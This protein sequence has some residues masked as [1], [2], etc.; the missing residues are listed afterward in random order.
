MTL[1][2]RRSYVGAAVQCTLTS[3]ITGASS[4]ISLTGDTTAWND[5]ANGPF[6]I[7]VDPGL[8]SEEKILVGSRSTSTLSSLTRGVDGTSAQSHAAGA[9]VYP[10]FTAVDADEANKLA[11]TMT[12]KGDLL[13]TDGSTPN[14]LAVGSNNQFLV[15]DSAATNGV[16]WTGT[17]SGATVA[18]GSNT[19]SGT[20]AEFDTAV[21]DDNFAYVGTANTFTTNQVISASSSSDLLRITQTG[22]GNAILVE[23]STNP[24]STPFVVDASGYVG[25][26]TSTPYAPATYGALTVDGTTGSIYSGR[27]NGTEHFRIQ[28]TATSTTLNGIA[29]V[30]V[31]FNT[32]NTERMRIDSAGQVGIGAAAVAGRTLAVAKPLTGATTAVGVNSNGTI[33]SDVTAEANGF[34]SVINTAAASFT[35]TNLLHFYA[36]PSATPGA[37]STITT[38]IGFAV[39]NTMTGASSNNYAFY[40]DLASGT[41]RYNLMMNG[42][43]ANYLAGRLG[44]GAT[45]TSGAMAQVTNTTAADK[46]LVVK[47]AASQ[48]GV[49]FE[50]QDS[51]GTAL[52]YIT[53]SGN[54]FTTSGGFYSTVGAILRAGGTSD[55]YIDTA[56]G[57]ASHG[58]IIFRS[59]S[60]FTERMRIDSAGAVSIGSTQAATSLNLTKNISG[61]TN[62]QA[63]RIASPVATG[64]TGEARYISIVPSVDASVAVGNLVGTKVFGATLG[65]SASITTQYGFWAASDI[66]AATTNYGFY[67]DIASGTGRW[68]LYMNGTAANYLAGRLGVGVTNNSGQMVAIVNTTAS[69][70]ALLV[71]GAAAQTANLLSIQNSAGTELARIDSTGTIFDLGSNVSTSTV[72]MQ[73]GNGRTGNGDSFIDLIG[74]TTYTDF[75][76]RIFRTSGANGGTLLSHRG[77]GDLRLRAVDAGFVSVYTSDTERMRIDSSGNVNVG[78]ATGIGYQS[79]NVPKVG[80]YAAG[81][82][83]M[84]AARYTADTG[85][86]IFAFAKSR[87]ATIGAVDVVSSGDNIGSIQFFGT[88]GTGYIN[89]AR[90]EAQV[91][92]TP[93]TNDMPGRLTFFTTADGASSVSERMRIDNAGNLGVNMSAFS[94]AKVVAIGNGTAPTANPTGG[95]YLYVEAGALK[96]RGSSGTITTIA[97][98]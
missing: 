48:T 76:F 13:V 22:S 40:G 54:Y 11:S 82:A 29:N 28:S 44:V 68:N 80:V 23:D 53:S 8:A 71:K 59:S 9:I 79:G 60:A 27:V 3:A 85:S 16:K 2:V 1:P 56:S 66:T 91:D 57:T 64:V 6:Y 41:G 43:A 39:A 95:G 84:G 37:G 55:V 12:T 35:L 65:A 4:S 32:N 31:I 78:N 90:I 89:A 58:S 25:I 88:D 42:T 47:G 73:L 17:L 51:A 75:G 26:G 45:L 18:L 20:K 36:A 96:Y 52:A 74:D 97:N 63:L 92:G 87:G 19:V 38:Q 15:A 70:F 94:G 30:P 62:S 34:R 50:A 98:A 5:T 14:R 83:V 33:Q 7:V 49:L 61:S 10:I 67:G 69:D 21:T 93:G 77:T 24:D 72:A 81:A 46:V 86:G